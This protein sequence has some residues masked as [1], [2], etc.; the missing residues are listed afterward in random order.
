[1]RDRYCAYSRR[2][3]SATKNTST[4]ANTSHVQQLGGGSLTLPIFLWCWSNLFGVVVVRSANQRAYLKH[5]SS[6]VRHSAVRLVA[7]ASAKDPCLPCRVRLTLGAPSRIVFPSQPSIL[8]ASYFSYHALPN[9]QSGLQRLS[10]MPVV[11]SSSHLGILSLTSFVPTVLLSKCRIFL[12]F[13]NPFCLDGKC[14]P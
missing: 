3:H 9:C 10:T 7:K 11:V 2:Q 14:G 13:K 6:K 5:V 8:R 4:V 12:L 1:M